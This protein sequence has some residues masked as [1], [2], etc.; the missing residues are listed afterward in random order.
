MVAQEFQP[1]NSQ[2][3][4]DEAARTDPWS[5]AGIGNFERV[6]RGL[7]CILAS[8]SSNQPAPPVMD[9][10]AVPGRLSPAAEPEP[11]VFHGSRDS[12]A[13]PE[14]NA[15][16]EV[17]DDE[18]NNL[19]CSPS[20]IPDSE[21]E[22]EE[23]PSTNRTS[24]QADPEN[25]GG[26][27]AASRSRSLQLPSSSAGPSVPRL[28]PE[29]RHNKESRGNNMRASAD[30]VVHADVT[31]ASSSPAQGNPWLGFSKKYQATCEDATI[32]ED[33][34][35]DL[36]ESAMQS[37]VEMQGRYP[38]DSRDARTSTSNQMSAGDNTARGFPSPQEQLRSDEQAQP[39]DTPTS[40]LKPPEPVSKTT[41]SVAQA[42]PAA[43]AAPASPV[44]DAIHMQQSSNRPPPSPRHP[45]GPGKAWKSKSGRKFLSR[46]GYPPSHGISRVRHVPGATPGTA[47][48]SCGSGSRG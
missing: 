5:L 29:T 46:P 11:D 41:N 3:T 31:A 4:Q 40:M 18:C 24:L 19:F 38:S 43:P 34:A 33:S 14:G 35:E 45:L 25:P 32:E 13:R 10:I 37:L 36:I 42:A 7:G 28:Q 20:G 27:R 15:S 23:E 47:A 9:E 21:S 6:T 12:P 8:T 2:S 39:S 30:P 16:D 1:E 26:S 48:T 22:D 17:P 44:K